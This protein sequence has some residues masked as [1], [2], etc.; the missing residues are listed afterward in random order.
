MWMECHHSVKCKND[1]FPN[2]VWFSESPCWVCVLVL[3][4]VWIPEPTIRCCLAVEPGWTSNP[5]S[6]DTD[7][8]HCLYKKKNECEISE[9]YMKLCEKCSHVKCAKTQVVLNQKRLIDKK[10]LVYNVQ[11]H[12][13]NGW[14]S[15]NTAKDHNVKY[16]KYT[17]M[18][19]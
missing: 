5:V 10:N 4:V 13:L 1:V 3:H 11:W 14:Q 17:N 6:S 19:M 2:G 9:S 12:K 8:K 15:S 16:L 7:H 18:K